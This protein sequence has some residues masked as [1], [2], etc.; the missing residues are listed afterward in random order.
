MK[1]N[2]NK[3]ISFGRLIEQAKLCHKCPMMDFRRTFLN[4]YNGNLEAELF[5]VGEATNI[6]TPDQLPRPFSDSQSARNFDMY[7]AKADIKRDDVFVTNTVLHTPLA[8]NSYKRARKPN[9]EEIQNCSAFL[10]RQ[11][12]LVNPKIVIALGAIAL[13]ALSLIEKHS[14][15]VSNNAGSIKQWFDRWIFPMYHPSPN[16]L[17]Y[18]STE[19]QIFDYR[20]L[21]HMLGA[22]NKFKKE[23]IL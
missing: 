8:D 1:I 6:G 10:K 11:I 17:S 5:F 13:S 16:T 2:V 3:L 23:K 21:K 20:E 14:L 19:R 9:N 7:L 15:S 12:E 4:Q 18:R 22:I